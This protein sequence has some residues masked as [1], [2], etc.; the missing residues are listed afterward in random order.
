MYKL[1]PEERGKNILYERQVSHLHDLHRKKVEGMTSH[2]V[3][4]GFST[5]PKTIPKVVRANLKKRMREEERLAE[6]EAENAR[7]LGQMSKIML[8]PD[9]LSRLK[10][11]PVSSLNIVTRRREMERVTN[12][13][14]RILKNLEAAPSYYNHRVWESERKE[15]EH[16]LTYIGLYPYQDGKGVK[17]SDNRRPPTGM[18]DAWLRSVA[19]VSRKSALS[20]PELTKS[21]AVMRFSRADSNTGQWTLPRLGGSGSSGGEGR[22]TSL[23]S[24]RAA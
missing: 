15:T 7:L 19:A 8:A 1:R 18:D 21:A 16:I 10:K 3:K 20:L 2:L 24:T 14:L 13:N 11:P 5:K 9:T 23:G 22:R 12:D 6:I 4:L 17:K